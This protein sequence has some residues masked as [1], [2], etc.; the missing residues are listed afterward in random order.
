MYTQ[1]VLYFKIFS[2]TKK[3][4]TL[5]CIA[6]SKNLKNLKEISIQKCDNLSAEGLTYLLYSELA[7]SLISIDLRCYFLGE[8]KLNSKNVVAIMKSLSP[9]Q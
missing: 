7:R 5:K 1:H 2:Q 6:N 4:S 9:L 8:N 3:D